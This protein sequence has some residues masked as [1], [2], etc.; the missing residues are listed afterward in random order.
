MQFLQ[1]ILAF[2]VV[3]GVTFSSGCL[4]F[5]ATYNI[6]TSKIV[7]TMTDN[8]QK[9]CTFSGIVAKDKKSVMKLFQTLAVISLFTVGYACVKLDGKY[10]WGT[11]DISATITDNGKKTCTYSGKLRDAHQFLSCIPRFSAFIDG[12][13]TWASYS[14]NGN[15]GTIQI[16]KETTGK[17]ADGNG[18]GK[19]E[20]FLAGQAFGC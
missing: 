4:V 19:D 16:I 7:G 9:T 6:D 5:D 14:N 17:G 13:L 10:N 2:V 3:F 18:L 12:S 11:H 8:G 15:E 1:A 20:F